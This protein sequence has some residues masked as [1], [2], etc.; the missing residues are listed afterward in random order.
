MSTIVECASEKHLELVPTHMRQIGMDDV[1]NEL[2]PAILS[3]LDDRD[4]MALSRVS[5]RFNQIALRIYLARHDVPDPENSLLLDT[6]HPTVFHAM[7]TALFIRQT[8]CVTCVIRGSC[9]DLPGAISAFAQFVKTLEHVEMAFICFG[10]IYVGLDWEYGKGET[11]IPKDVFSRLMGSLLNAF[12]VTSCR[13]LYFYHGKVHPSIARYDILQEWMVDASLSRIYSL[14]GFNHC[15]LTA[16]K[17]SLSHF[18]AVLGSAHW[19]TLRS[20]WNK[21]IL[22]SKPRVSHPVSRHT[23]LDISPINSLVTMCIHSTFLLHHPFLSWTVST[24]HHSEIV[25]LTLKLTDSRISGKDMGIFFSLLAMPAL[26][27]LRLTIEH[28]QLKDLADFLSR[29]QVID[30][31]LTTTRLLSDDGDVA[32]ITQLLLPSSAMW[33]SLATVFIDNL[34]LFLKYIPSIPNIGMLCLRIDPV[35]F[36]QVDVALRR[37]SEVCSGDVELRLDFFEPSDL[38]L[39]LTTGFHASE[40]RA[41]CSL[42]CVKALRLGLC[43]LSDFAELTNE[44]EPKGFARL[45]SAVTRYLELFPSLTHVAFDNL[46]FDQLGEEAPVVLVSAIRGRCPR[47]TCIS[48]GNF[49][50]P[51]DQ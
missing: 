15:F 9:W 18:K 12:S 39:Y 48:A 51:A 42:T 22:K 29:H 44:M 33:L 26:R 25:S 28:L 3:E 31:D 34:L 17:R 32:S 19:K 36:E 11:S 5:L 50:C 46:G 47:I 1:P 6:L 37:L 20:H 8:R 13:D 4:L 21:S 14:A 38:A 2:L 49:M 40:K 7:T 30:L 41:E 43:C 27:I 23:S 16:A 45:V 10:G 35:D 24:L